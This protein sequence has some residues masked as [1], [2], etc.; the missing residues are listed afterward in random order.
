MQAFVRNGNI[1]GDLF[2]PERDRANGV[3]I[4]WCPGLPNTPTA[5]DMSSPLSNAGFTV[6][7]ARY[8]GSWQSYGKFGPSSSIEGAIQGLELLSKGSTIDLSTEEIVEW[9]V[10]RLVLVGNSYG[11]AVAACALAVSDLADS[12]VL[13][14]PLLE[15]AQQNA[16]L[17]EPESDLTTL[18]S[19]LKRCQENVF[20]HIDE[21]E[22]NE[23]L[24]GSS[25]L[26]PPSHISKL[27]NRKMLLIHGK[28]D[29]TIRSYHTERFYN[30]LIAES[31]DV[32]AQLLVVDGVGHGK[33]NY[34]LR[35]GIIGSTG[36]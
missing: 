15:P 18:L 6:L 8:P 33:N 20:R 23:F 1:L 5:E 14:C 34:V 26:N 13:F 31:N 29:D 30:S 25:L 35:L 10:N 36:Y 17:T 12:A 9:S 32:K 27:V 28:E 7:Q 19:Y 24:V 11:G 2:L 16:E 22:W 4:V 21:N 3:G